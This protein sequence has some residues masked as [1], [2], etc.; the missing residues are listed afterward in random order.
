MLFSSIILS[1]AILA[2]IVYI[3]PGSISYVQASTSPSE[4]A[5]LVLEILS[6][7]AFMISQF[8]SVTS[9]SQ[10]FEHLKKTFYLALDILAQESHGAHDDLPNTY[11]KDQSLVLKSPSFTRGS[12]FFNAILLCFLTIKTFKLPPLFEMQ[13]RRL[14]W[15]ALNSLSQYCMKPMSGDMFLILVY[16]K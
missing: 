12:Q 5:L 13:K 15:Q 6:C 14:Y 10:G 16:R 2:S 9:T 8:G 7:S 4:L 11:V 1:D 3:E